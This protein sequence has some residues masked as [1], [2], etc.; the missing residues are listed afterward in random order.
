MATVERSRT[1]HA[2]L[3]E[4]WRVVDDPHHQPRWWPG[5][6]RMEQIDGG[7]FTQ[8]HVSKRG[9]PVRMDFT[10]T[11]R[12]PPLDDTALLA[13]LEW[14]Q[15]LQGTP[16]DRLLTLSAIEIALEAQERSTIV[17]IAQSQRLRGASRTGSWLARRA[18][19]R[20]LGEALAGLD[21]LFG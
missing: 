18:S 3:P 6:Q 15:E 12:D 1:I 14:H 21:A 16:F 19:R 4:V 10:V 20:K 11:R 7:R 17:T 8:V 2:T 5:V 9:R 13:G